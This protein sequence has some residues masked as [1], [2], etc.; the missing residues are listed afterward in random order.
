[1]NLPRNT[2]LSTA[3]GKKNPRCFGRTHRSW[4]GAK[5][6]PAQHN[7]YA[8]GGTHAQDTLSA[9]APFVQVFYPFHPLHGASFQV[10]RRPKCGD[11]AVTVL[12]INGRRLKVP[13]WMLSAE[14]AD[15]R[16]AEQAYL[17]KHALQSLADLLAI[18]L[19][20]EDNNH[21]NLLPRV[22]GPQ[23]G[24]RGAVATSQRNDEQSSGSARRRK[25]PQRGHQS[26][27]PHSRSRIS[28]SGGKK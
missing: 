27:G 7:G 14:A 16:I 12:D 13:R 5:P 28:N 11:G 2:L 25:D 21:D 17:S 23:G 26:D 18:S 19:Q 6:P 20:T 1:V 3:I 8:D 24:Q 9:E 22:T 4:L 10:I 15:T